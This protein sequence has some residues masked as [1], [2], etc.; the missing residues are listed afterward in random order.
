[1]HRGDTKLF[2]DEVWYYADEDRAVA[3]GNVVFRQGE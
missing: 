1:M 2:A 3:T